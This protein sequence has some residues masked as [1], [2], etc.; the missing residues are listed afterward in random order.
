MPQLRGAKAREVNS[1]CSA[2]RKP[3]AE[4][5]GTFA[6]ARAS[7]SQA[8]APASPPVLRHYTQLDIGLERDR[9]EAFYF[10][11]HLFCRAATDL[12]ESLLYF[13]AFESRRGSTPRD[14]ARQLSLGSLIN[15][16]R[17]KRRYGSHQ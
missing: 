9:R 16:P 14:K 2:D 17:T 12:V 15:S 13:R 4:S 8:D 5:E 3:E 7:G 11:G 1:R 10:L 6:L